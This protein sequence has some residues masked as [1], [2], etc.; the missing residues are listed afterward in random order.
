MVFIRRLLYL[1][2]YFKES[3]RQMLAKFLRYSSVVTGRS[4]LAI[5]SDA[6]VSAVR[7]NISFK[8]YF[9]FRFYEPGRSD[10]EEWAGTGF[11]YEYQLRMNPKDSRKILK[12]KILFLGHFRDLIKRDFVSL[13]GGPDDVTNLSV[14]LNNHAGRIALKGS[15]GQVGAEVEIVKCDKYTPETL[16]DHMKKKHYDLAEEFVV[17]HSDLNELSPSGLNTVRVITQ[18][19]DGEVIILGARL[20]VSVNSPVDNMAA[21]NLAAPVDTETGTVTGPGVYSD[22]TKEPESVHPV[23]GMK[24]EGFIIPHWESVVKL[25]D[26][27]ARRAGGNRSVGWDIAITAEGPEL[28]EGNHNWCK[29]L[30]QLPVKR[31]LK[32]ELTKYL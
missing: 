22:I 20:R 18:Y 14:L 8:D 29:L 32:R 10:R 11:M 15:L 13:S 6:L 19:H 28:I 4:R 27:V 17:Q 9:C 5:A 2:Y 16:L 3:D 26:T 7:Y 25:A 12:N 31:G 30:W 1:F 24:I 23:T 21:G